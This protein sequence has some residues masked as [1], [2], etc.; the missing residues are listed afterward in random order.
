VNGPRPP[1]EERPPPPAA[2]LGPAGGAGFDP[3]AFARRFKSAR[4]ALGR[5]AYFGEVFRFVETTE[6]TNDLARDWVAPEGAVVAAGAQT[7]GRGRGGRAW[8][9]DAGAGLWFSVV[10]R[11]GF[12][13][14]QAGM[15]P[16]ALGFGL[17][18]ALRRL[19]LPAALKW[20]NDILIGRRKLAGVLV[21]GTMVGDRLETAIAGIGVNWVRPTLA[22]LSYEA[23]GL[24]SELFGRSGVGPGTSAPPEPEE[25]LV[26]L[27][28]GLEQAYLVLKAAGSAPFVAAWPAVC[29][30]FGRPVTYRDPSGDGPETTALSGRLAL[31]GALE[32]STFDGR[33]RRLDS[34]GVSLSLGF[35][36]RP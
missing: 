5:A 10:L 6:S 25:V 15:I 18:I 24:A 36:Q 1:S 2:P 12:P 16:P 27:L 11:P 26:A 31:D 8:I 9:S 33:R 3:T 19:G 29:A 34:A 17:V 7:A 23:T 32:V 35:P 4:K 22:G 14:P 30:H 21:E 13:Y 28:D 20:P